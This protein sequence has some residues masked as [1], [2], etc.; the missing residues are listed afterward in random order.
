MVLPFDN[1]CMA[2]INLVMKVRIYKSKAGEYNYFAPRGWNGFLYFTDG[3]VKYYYDDK[4][5]ICK[6]GTFAY[7]PIG[8]PYRV[9]QTDGFCYLINFRIPSSLGEEPFFGI[10]EN[11]SQI[12]DCFLKAMTVFQ[13][14]RI[15][16]R[17]EL[18]S[19]FYRIISLVQAGGHHGSLPMRHYSLIEPAVHHI[20]ENYR[21]KE[22]KVE[23]LA[24]LCGISRKY[25]TKLFS[26]YYDL[27]PKQYIINLKLDYAR[28]LLISEPQMSIMQISEACLFSNVYYFSRLFSEHVGQSPSEYRKNK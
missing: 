21:K 7:L 13:K 17:A 15:G 4:E 3:V 11:G 25:F 19:I 2:N 9:S 10:F 27:T 12:L 5:Y 23:E 1:A 28:K 16:Y 22:I 14:K 18:N 8:K 24:A 20:S 6:P 26:T